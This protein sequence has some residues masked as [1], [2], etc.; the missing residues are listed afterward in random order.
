MDDIDF[1]DPLVA[2]LRGDLAAWIAKLPTDLQ[3]VAPEIRPDFGRQETIGQ[4]MGILLDI[5]GNFPV[6]E[7]IYNEIGEAAILR[8]I[9][10]IAAVSKHDGDMGDVAVAGLAK[11]FPDTV[12][13]VVER[14]QTA[15]GQRLLSIL[16]HN[17]RFILA[18]AG[19]MPKP[20]PQLDFAAMSVRV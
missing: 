13:R 18:V 17:P 7:S 14:L 11:N 5:E 19:S 20:N 4:V 15:V 9:A 1:E 8:I 3:A 6:E 10:R 12:G 2:P 16:T